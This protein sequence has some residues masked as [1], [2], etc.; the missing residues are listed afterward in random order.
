MQALP[1]GKLEGTQVSSC[2]EQATVDLASEGKGEGA[3]AGGKDVLEESSE[4]LTLWQDNS[5]LRET[6][7]VS[8][9]CA[10]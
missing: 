8:G 4:S 1:G 6:S 5:L 10:P 9:V 2:R 7:V 3:A